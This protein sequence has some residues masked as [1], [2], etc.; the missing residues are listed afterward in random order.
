MW[1][2]SAD[3]K[4]AEPCVGMREKAAILEQGFHILKELEESKQAKF[5]WRDEEGPQTGDRKAHSS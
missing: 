5:Q 1:R 2:K 3:T 4:E